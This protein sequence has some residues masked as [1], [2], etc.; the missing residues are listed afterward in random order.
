MTGGVRRIGRA[1]AGERDAL[2][3]AR[4]RV[5]TR[6]LAIA[7]FRADGEDMD[8]LGDRLRTQVVKQ[9]RIARCTTGSRGRLDQKDCVDG[10]GIVRGSHPGDG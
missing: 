6:G 4:S 10:G 3:P 1:F 8:E 9:L 5:R 7:L 2:E